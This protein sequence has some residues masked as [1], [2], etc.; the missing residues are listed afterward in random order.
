MSQFPLASVDES[1][2]DNDYELAHTVFLPTANLN[3]I[4]SEISDNL[5]L[6]LLS[7]ELVK[8]GGSQ[9]A[10]GKANQPSNR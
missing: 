2:S 4:A 5:P 6:K 8:N 3:I 7:Q 1:T 10:D 9:C